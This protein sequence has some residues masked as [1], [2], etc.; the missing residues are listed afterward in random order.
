MNTKLNLLYNDVS[1][2]HINNNLNLDL[3]EAGSNSNRNIRSSR[4]IHND[5]EL[6]QQL[7]SPLKSRSF[8]VKRKTILPF[9]THTIIR[10]LKKNIITQ[11]PSKI[12]SAGKKR[13]K[14][15]I[16]PSRAMIPSNK[17]SLKSKSLQTYTRNS[18]KSSKQKSYFGI[19]KKLETTF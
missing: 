9:K 8:V 2:K 4:F 17:I 15:K 1:M 19:R 3:E 12:V 14:Q 11:V 7:D 10:Q 16:L 18:R 13:R 5:Y 6:L